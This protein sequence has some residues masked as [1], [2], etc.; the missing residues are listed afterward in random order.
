MEEIDIN[1]VKKIKWRISF[2]KI[3]E[4]ISEIKCKYIHLLETQ[5]SEKLIGLKFCSG[6]VISCSVTS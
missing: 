1:S 6:R 3:D 5:D 4:N 2:R